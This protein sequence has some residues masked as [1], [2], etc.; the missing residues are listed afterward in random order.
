MR[1]CAPQTI[2]AFAART[3]ERVSYVS[4][5]IGLNCSMCCFSASHSLG[6]HAILKVSALYD[7]YPSK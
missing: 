3:Q 1:R 5:R 2:A 4:H 6:S 7:V